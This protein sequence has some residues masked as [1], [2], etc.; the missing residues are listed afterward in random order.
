MHKRIQIKNATI[1]NEGRRFVGSLLIDNDRIEQ[2]LEGRDAVTQIPADEV[3]DAEGCYL[4][5]GMIDEHVHFREPGLTHKADMECESRAAAAG[6]VTT[7][8]DM[9]NTLPQTTSMDEFDEKLERAAAQSHV[10]FGF[11]IG[12]TN[13]NSILFRHLNPRRVAGVKL[14]M[15]SSTGNMLVD[16]EDSLRR[17]FDESPI[18]I[19]THCE[20]SDLIAR[21][22][23]QIRAS[24]VSTL[25]ISLHAQIRSEE[26]CYRSSHVAVSLAREYGARLLV[27]HISTARELDLFTPT[28]PPAQGAWIGAEACLG[29]L[30]FCDRDY[31][32][33]GARIKVNPSIKTQKDRDALRRALLDGRITTVAT[34]HAPHLIGEKAGGADTAASG[35][36][37]IQFSLTAMLELTRKGVLEI[38]DVV[39][40]MCHRPADVFQIENRG[41]LREGYKADLVLVRPDAPWTLTPNLIRSKCN[42]SPLEGSVFHWRVE[43]TYCNGFLVYNMGHLTDENIH[44][45]PVTFGR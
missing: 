20:D 14:F 4:L 21:N 45:E 38:E 18:L 15:G 41:Y 36:P 19:M 7:W 30:L 39:R 29:H 12:A 44:G 22:L 9:P 17:I 42:W 13:D 8:L 27:A 32:R 35:M 28:P 6:G 26:A 24:H 25:P 3:V 43:K 16:R 2:V 40:L 37:M 23:R 1:I 11:F 10:N 33:L 5:P 31:Q 34:D